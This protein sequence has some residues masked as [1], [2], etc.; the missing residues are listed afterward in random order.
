VIYY[1][2]LLIQSTLYYSK[3]SSIVDMSGT[4]RK[5]SSKWDLSDEHKFSPGSKQM[6]SGRSSADV[7]GSNSSEW[8]YLEGND[9]LRP[10]TGFSSKESF[11]G[12]RG[13]NEDDAMNKDHRV[14]DS[15]REW[16]TDGSYSR[17]MRHSQSPKNDW[18]RSVWFYF[19]N[20]DIDGNYNFFFIL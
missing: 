12:G 17:N 13:S 2:L 14:L 3:R 8:A 11:Y 9:K 16:D 18:S 5:H 15:R 20:I 7:A 6:R 10:V 4:G 19:L 1:L